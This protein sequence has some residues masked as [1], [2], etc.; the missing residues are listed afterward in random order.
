[1]PGAY[2]ALARMI[3]LPKY[4]TGRLIPNYARVDGL[5]KRKVDEIS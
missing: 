1:M 2:A 4:A 3:R 5:V